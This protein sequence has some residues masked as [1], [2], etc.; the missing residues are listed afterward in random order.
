M[1]WNATGLSFIGKCGAGEET[2]RK[3]TSEQCGRE[4]RCL[5]SGH[6]IQVLSC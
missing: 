3:K 5:K 1:E 2:R 4:V 6:F